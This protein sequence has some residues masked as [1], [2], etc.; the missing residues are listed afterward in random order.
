MQKLNSSVMQCLEPNCHQVPS[1]VLDGEGEGRLGN[2]YT[3]VQA[4]VCDDHSDYGKKYLRQ[5][6]PGLTIQETRYPGW[7]LREQSKLSTR[8][9]NETPLAPT[10]EG[11]RKPFTTRKQLLDYLANRNIGRRK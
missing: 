11:A 7:L 8:I 1:I 2:R 10:P 9:E 5:N 4:L 3:A 6:Y